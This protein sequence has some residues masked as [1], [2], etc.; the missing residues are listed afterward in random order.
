[1]KVLFLAHEL[2]T[3]GPVVKLHAFVRYLRERGDEV[4][5]ACPSEGLYASRLREIGCAVVRETRSD[6]HDV[7]VV[8][9][10]VVH[11][12]AMQ[13][14]RM[15]PVVC[16]LTEGRSI[17]HNGTTSMRE[18]VS[19]FSSMTAVVFVSRV[20]RD[21]IF[22]SFL[23]ET[24]QRRLHVI[25]NGCLPPPD[26]WSRRDR[27]NPVP[28]IVF[29][30]SVYPR[31]R[32]EHLLQAVRLLRGPRPECIYIG[33][34]VNMALCGPDLKQAA[35][36]GE[37]MLTGAVPRERIFDLAREGDVF[38]LP[39][40]DEASPL[41]VLD[42]GLMGLAPVLTDLSVYDGVW[43]HGQNCLMAP[44][45]DVEVL[46]AML[47]ALLD[48]PA[49]RARVALEATETSKRHSFAD[50]AHRLRQVLVRSA[51]PRASTP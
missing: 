23:D 51:R 19:F 9:T 4:T 29:I 7:A 47:Q 45:G 12:M 20:Q 34:T 10:M 6:D 13:I 49:L 21:R 48:R 44:V 3:T 26:G 40:T 43:K 42:A 5:V 36:R 14:S 31:K 38:C 50:Y 2:G 15:L 30:G 27:P 32:P 11:K 37:I 35:D 28:R 8:L 24:D 25:E 22:T 16:L 17:V 39:S 1:M 41:S 18:V 33:D 46:S